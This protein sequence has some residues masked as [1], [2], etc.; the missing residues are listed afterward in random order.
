[1]LTIE[2]FDTFIQNNLVFDQ[3]LLFYI[4]DSGRENLIENLG[5]LHS[6]YGKTIKMEG[7]EKYNKTIFNYCKSFDYCGPVSCHIFRSFPDSKS[8]PM[9]S[10]PDDVLLLMTS[11]SKDIII[12]D[13]RHTLEEN[14]TFF[15]SANT[16]HQAI[17]TGHSLMLSIGFERYLIDKL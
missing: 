4:D 17:N 8:F 6:I 12:S 9:H 14:K 3:R 1:M 2:E 5:Q 15:I 16:P 13:Y 10:D 7:A 11:G